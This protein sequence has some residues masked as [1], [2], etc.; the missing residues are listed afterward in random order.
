[1]GCRLAP[2]AGPARLSGRRR[3]LTSLPARLMMVLLICAGSAS[4]QPRTKILIL[5]S[6]AGPPPEGFVEALSIQLAGS[7]TMERSGEVRGSLQERL[8]GVGKPLTAH[9]ASVGVWVERTAA[10][11]ASP[12]FLVYVVTPRQDR[13]LVQVV[14]LP[15]PESPETERALALKVREVLDSVVQAGRDPDVSAPLRAERAHPPTS[16]PRPTMTHWAP[17]FVGDLTGASAGNAL[18]DPQLGAAL[19]AGARVQRASVAGEAVLTAGWASGAHS[20]RSGGTADTSEFELGIG[21][22]AL[23]VSETVAAGLDTGVWARAV[24]AEGTAADGRSGRSTKLVPALRAG[25][26][27]RV[28]VTDSVAVRT[29][30]GLDV[31]LV[32]QSFSVA[33]EVVS[34][35][36][37]VRGVGSVGLVVALP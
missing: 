24:R 26:E 30:V 6:D 2:L 31:A 7:M 27:V 20:E 22:R 29:A 21:L 1:M 17:L 23:Y 28:N 34:D 11:G 13:V 4:A 8:R 9:R 25:P 37:R 32:R 15:G 18:Y 3:L 5:G 19:G 33:G 12:E 35:L 36:G 10:P 16:A 14:R